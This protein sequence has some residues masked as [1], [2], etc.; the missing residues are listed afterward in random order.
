MAKKGL[1]S[2]NGEGT[3]ASLA[4][5]NRKLTKFAAR[6]L[7]DNFIDASERITGLNRR[8][9][10][11]SSESPDDT[12]DIVPEPIVPASPEATVDNDLDIKAAVSKVFEL[13]KPGLISKETSLTVSAT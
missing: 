3:F 12:A 1:L 9:L 2:P 10:G 6:Y 5:I 13:C 7:P 4:A 8:R 11:L